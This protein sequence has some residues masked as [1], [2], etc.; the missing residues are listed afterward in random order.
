ML[1]TF[2]AKCLDVFKPNFMV[3]TVFLIKSICDLKL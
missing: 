1:Q 3:L 2:D